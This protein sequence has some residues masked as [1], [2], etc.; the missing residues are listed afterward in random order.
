MSVLS[1]GPSP[2][3]RLLEEARAGSADAFWQLALGYRPYLRAV[4][5]RV[6]QGQFPSDGSDVVQSGLSVAFERLHQFRGPG[7]APFLAWLAAIVGNEA[8]RSLG[9]ARRFQPLPG[10]SSDRDPLAGDS[11]GPDGKAAKR[12]QAARLLAAVER[13]PDD[14]RTVL[15]LRIFQELPF[16]EVARRMGRSEDAAR[17]LWT[18]ALKKLRADLGEE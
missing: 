14:H 1:A 4:A 12:E 6:L 15:N 13:L 3:D 5:A 2:L 8:R 17:Q 11:S 10:D 7:A 18:R 9:Q 16:E